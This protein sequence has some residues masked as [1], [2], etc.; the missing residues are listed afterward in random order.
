MGGG[1]EVGSCNVTATVLSHLT[2]F[3][4]TKSKCHTSCSV[5]QDDISLYL[6]NLT[7]VDIIVRLNC[8]FDCS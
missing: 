7:S 1:E 4:D 6:Y 3:Q 8:V 2:D 5:A